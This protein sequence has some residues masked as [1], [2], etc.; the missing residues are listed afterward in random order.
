VAVYRYKKEDLNPKKKGSWFTKKPWLMP[1]MGLLLFMFLLA[2]ATGPPRQTSTTKDK[3]AAS[4]SQTKTLTEE[5][6]REKA[7]AE[8]PSYKCYWEEGGS[9]YFIT[10]DSKSCKESLANTEEQIKKPLYTEQQCKQAKDDLAKAERDRR[11]YE[12]GAYATGAKLN[13]WTAD[14]DYSIYKQEREKAERI[15][16]Y[17]K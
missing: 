2:V 13:G 8:E 11:N 14:A 9:D 6:P 3:P 16:Y 15:L 7:E 1:A 12:V 4:A 5:M 10:T 17:C